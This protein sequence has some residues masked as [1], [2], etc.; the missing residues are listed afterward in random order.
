MFIRELLGSFPYAIDVVRDVEFAT[1]I[2][3]FAKF[4]PLNELFQPLNDGAGLIKARELK[5]LFQ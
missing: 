2:A 4:L 3:E 1:E 5:S